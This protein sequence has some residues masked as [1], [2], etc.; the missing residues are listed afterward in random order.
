MRTSAILA[1]EK[2]GSD[3]TYYTYFQRKLLYAKVSQ[4]IT[5]PVAIRHEC[6]CSCINDEHKRLRVGLLDRIENIGPGRQ[7]L[8]MDRQLRSDVHKLGRK[9][10]IRK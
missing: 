9:Q 10:T 6:C 1:L 3:G 7:C 8:D 2:V 5:I 4:I